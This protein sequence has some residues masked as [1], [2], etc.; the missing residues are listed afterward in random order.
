MSVWW[1]S[2]TLFLVLFHFEFSYCLVLSCDGCHK[3]DRNR[4]RR[5]ITTYETFEWNIHLFL[6]HFQFSVWALISFCFIFIRPRCTWGPIYGSSFSLT[7][8]LSERGFW[9]LTYLTLADQATNSIQTDNAI[10]AI[11]G[12]VAMQVTNLVDNFG[13]HANGA[14][15]WR[16]FK[17]MQV[18]PLGEPKVN[19]CKWWKWHSLVIKF[20]TDASTA[21]RWK[22]F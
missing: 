2:D 19:W 5:K 10:M 15:C 13:T 21:N 8:S 17:L 16:K 9:N 20:V 22:I 12:N 7:H 14:T 18:V 3:R 6:I 11:Q 4:N 1:T